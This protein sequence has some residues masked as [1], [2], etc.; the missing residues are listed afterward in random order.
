MPTYSKLFQTIQLA[1]NRQVLGTLQ[2]SVNRTQSRRMGGKRVQ[3]KTLSFLRTFPFLLPSLRTFEL[4]LF[5]FFSPKN[6][7]TRAFLLR[8]IFPISPF[9]VAVLEKNKI[10]FCLFV[11][12]FLFFCFW[13]VLFSWPIVAAGEEFC[14][15]RSLLATH[16]QVAS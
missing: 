14:S 5:V 10:Q 3:S 13:W 8:F 11:C 7:L 1:T 2:E 16:S 4:V 6:I 12:F 15:C 9:P